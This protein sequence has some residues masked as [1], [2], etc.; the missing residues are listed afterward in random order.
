LL[1]VKDRHAQILYALSVNCDLVQLTQSGQDMIAAR[2]VGLF[3]A[4][5]VDNEDK[6]YAVVIVPK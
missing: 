4:E 5:V 1:V 2:S 3:D 6:G